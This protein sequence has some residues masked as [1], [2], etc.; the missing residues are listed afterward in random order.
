M[1]KEKQH[2]LVA[3]ANRATGQLVVEILRKSDHYQPIAMVRKEDQKQKFEQQHIKV[4]LADLE[5]DISHTMEGVDKVIFAAS[6]KSKNLKDV[7]QKGAKKIVD[8]ALDAGVQKYVMLSSIGA[9][10]PSV[11]EDLKDYL[12]AKKNADEY[13]MKSDLPYTVV[14]PGHLTHDDASNRVKLQKKLDEPGKIS[15]A[16]FAKTLVEVLEENVMKNETFELIQ[17]EVPIE[18]AVR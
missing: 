1:S 8:A 4:V 16:D 10:N 9:D 7:D 13:L 14:R 5:N 18:D 2:V 6:S 17:G 12:K 3:G 15:R 11:S